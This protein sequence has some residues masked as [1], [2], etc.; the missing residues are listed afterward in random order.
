MG[1]KLFLSWAEGLFF[2]LVILGIIVAVLSPSAFISYSVIF[3]SGFIAGRLIF[4]RKKKLK[5]AYYIIIFGFLIGFLL[6]SYYGDIKVI[7]ILFIL[8]AI[9]SYYL[10]DKKVFKDIIM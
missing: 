4:F 9:L 10:H 7:I 1:F 2:V 8:G 6:G 5:S 3:I